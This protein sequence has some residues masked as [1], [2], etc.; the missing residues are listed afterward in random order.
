MVPTS[1]LAALAQVREMTA[2]GEAKRIRTDNG[3]SLTEMATE[4]PV[5]TTT[6]FRWEEGERRPRGERALT[7]LRILL[8]LRDRL[9]AKGAA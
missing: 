8:E 7:Y 1:R 4:I 5:G 6:L 2:S 9:E 3:L